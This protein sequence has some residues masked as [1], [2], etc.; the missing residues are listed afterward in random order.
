MDQNK[1]KLKNELLAKLVAL[2]VCHIMANYQFGALISDQDDEYSISFM[3]DFEDEIDVGYDVF[4]VVKDFFESFLDKQ[5]PQGELDWNLNS[6]DFTNQ[7]YTIT[8]DKPKGWDAT[9]AAVNVAS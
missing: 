1:L 3:N 6:D 4:I 5:K 9:L 7:S 8:L 2:G